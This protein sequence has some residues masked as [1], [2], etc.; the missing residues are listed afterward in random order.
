[1]TD[2][3]PDQASSEPQERRDAAARSSELD[4]MARESA[5][6]TFGRTGNRPKVPG[7]ISGDLGP[8]GTVS[9]QHRELSRTQRDRLGEVPPGTVARGGGRLVLVP[10]L[11]AAALLLGIAA[12]IGWLAS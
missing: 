5:D 9:A 8:K 4:R 7:V 6:A 3:S 10:M 1:M 12:L 11:V 2:E